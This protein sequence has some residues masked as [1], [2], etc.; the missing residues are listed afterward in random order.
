M[1]NTVG[2]IGS[3]GRRSDAKKMTKELFY[4]MMRKTEALITQRLRLSLS[5]VRLVSGGAAWADHIAVMEYLEE[6][7]PE[8]SLHLPT[9][10]SQESSSPQF[11]DNG[12]SNIYNNPGRSANKLH[13][14]FSDKMGEDTL[15]HIQDAVHLGAEFRTYD[16]FHHRN[17]GVARE[18]KYLIAF[19][20]NE[21]ATPKKESGTFD[22]WKK[23]SG[24]KIHIPISSLADAGP[25]TKFLSSKSQSV[26]SDAVGEV[27]EKAKEEKCEFKSQ[28]SVDSGCCLSSQQSYE[29]SEPSVSSE[30][31]SLSACSDSTSVEG[32]NRPK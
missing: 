32:R 23:H 21:G 6:K 24:T 3:A 26:P 28:D 20:W 2:I 12:N 19:T 18:S 16:G 29:F 10:W 17:T 8:L 15:K 14:Q 31:P 7:V 25:I 1:A 4:A 9:E 5:H 22:T 13:R 11:L 27:S 30:T